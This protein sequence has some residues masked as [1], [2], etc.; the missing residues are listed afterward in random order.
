MQNKDLIS[1][2]RTLAPVC[3]CAALA[4]SHCTERRRRGS[5]HIPPPALPDARPHGRPR[6]GWPHR[7]R[8]RLP[9]ARKIESFGRGSDLALCGDSNHQSPRS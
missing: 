8:E 1:K 4:R 9:A 3:S 6:A 7:I 5:G 2:F